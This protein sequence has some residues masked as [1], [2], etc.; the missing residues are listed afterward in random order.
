MSFC[1]CSAFY[2]ALL[3]LLNATPLF[4]GGSHS[5]AAKAKRPEGADVSIQLDSHPKPANTPNA[6]ADPSHL[7]SSFTTGCVESGCDILPV[8]ACCVETHSF[9]WY[10]ATM[11]QPVNGQAF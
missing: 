9:L 7:L 5:A 4:R 8:K 10:V 6:S 11:W 2:F 1:S 3:W